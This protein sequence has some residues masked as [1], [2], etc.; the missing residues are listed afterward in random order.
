[1]FGTFL[2]QQAEVKKLENLATA[3]D[4]P[5]IEEY[6]RLQHCEVHLLYQGSSARAKLSHCHGDWMASTPTLRWTKASKS[7]EFRKIP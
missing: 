6:H 2:S 4:L 7:P 5:F 3:Q 1:M